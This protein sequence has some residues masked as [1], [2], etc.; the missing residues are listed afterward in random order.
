MGEMSNKEP[1]GENLHRNLSEENEENYRDEEKFNDKNKKI[2]S[3]KRIEEIFVCGADLH[4]LRLLFLLLSINII[5]KNSGQ[6]LASG[7]IQI[8]DFHVIGKYGAQDS[9]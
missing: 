2:E 5:S 6:Y 1:I 4:A 9:T 8:E 7:A 3:N